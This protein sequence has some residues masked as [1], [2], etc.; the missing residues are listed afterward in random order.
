MNITNCVKLHKSA[1]FNKIYLVSGLRR[2]GNHLLLQIL[3]CSFPDNSILFINDFPSLTNEN[4]NF[5]E[6]QFNQFEQNGLINKKLITMSYNY[7]FFLC[8]KCITNIKK[9]IDIDDINIL[10][11]VS[12]NW[13]E[14]LKC[15]KLCSIYNILK[16]SFLVLYI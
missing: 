8:E 13:T 4:I 11:S 7:S 9:L 12:E 2:S 16:L 15:Y 5:Q 3:N 1:K 6:E 10:E 14:T